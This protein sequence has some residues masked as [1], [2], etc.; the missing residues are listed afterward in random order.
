[1][2]KYYWAFRAFIW[3][4]AHAIRTA[5][6]GDVWAIDYRPSKLARLCYRA[7]LLWKVI[8]KSLPV[9]IGTGCVRIAVTHRVTVWASAYSLA[10]EYPAGKYH[11]VVGTLAEDQQRWEDWEERYWDGAGDYLASK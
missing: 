11:K 9:T 7:R 6:R 5:I 10:V 1:M 2:V 3:D 8:G 4:M